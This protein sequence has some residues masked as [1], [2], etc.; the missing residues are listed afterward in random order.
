MSSK[1]NLSIRPFPL[2]GQSDNGQGMPPPVYLTEQK[3]PS[4]TYR[5]FG[6][7]KK[8]A[9]NGKSTFHDDIPRKKRSFS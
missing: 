3:A 5:E 6:S 2:L 8:L 1:E 7:E 4:P 9:K